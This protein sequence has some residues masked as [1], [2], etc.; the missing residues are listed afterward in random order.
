[1]EARFSG[2][3]LHYFSF[4]SALSHGPSW[5]N[6]TAKDFFSFGHVLFWLALIG[7]NVYLFF[8][9]GSP[10]AAQSAWHI[11]VYK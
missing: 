5:P 8:F 9:P 4:F 7:F 3:L 1:M 11:V 10:Q 2:F 6:S